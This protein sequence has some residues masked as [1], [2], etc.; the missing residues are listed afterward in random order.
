[1]TEQSQTQTLPRLESDVLLLVDIVAERSDRA[2]LLPE[3]ELEAS[4]IE[5]AGK[6]TPPEVEA[7]KEEMDRS[8]DEAFRDK[9]QAA[10]HNVVHMRKKGETG[11]EP[12]ST[13]EQRKVLTRREMLTAL[14]SGNLALEA[15][16]VAEAA[17]E[18]APVREITHE[19][20]ES[21]LALALKGPYGLARLE[22][23]DKAVYYHYKPLLSCSYARMLSA[24]NNPIEMLRDAVRENSR[25]Y[26]RPVPLASFE[27]VPYFLSPEQIQEV[28]KHLS[29]DPESKDIRFTETSIGTVYL[30]STKYLEDDYADFLAE[31]FDVGYSES[32]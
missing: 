14:L 20:Y 19:Y 17:P 16:D 28:L 1:M 30:Y 31:Q 32:P 2:E 23:W 21:I 22:A 7:L 3:A 10:P 27:D 25:V 18:E 9:L 15:A 13:K 8:V 29:E 4:F 6:A 11:N 26:P 12:P 24:K 5:R